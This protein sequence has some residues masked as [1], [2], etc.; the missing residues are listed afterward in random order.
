MVRTKEGLSLMDLNMEIPDQTPVL[1]RLRARNLATDGKGTS[2]WY[3]PWET[4][5][6]HATY[7]H[8]PFPSEAGHFHGHFGF[9]DADCPWRD[10]E[11]LAYVGFEISGEMQTER[12]QA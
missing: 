5:V 7:W 11:I 2:W 6:V 8:T 10:V 1:V 3:T 12:I 4:Y 9:S